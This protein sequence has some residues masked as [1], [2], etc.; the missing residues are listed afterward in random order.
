MASRIIN[1]FDHLCEF[2][3]ALLVCGKAWVHLFVPNRSTFLYQTMGIRWMY[4]LDLKCAYEVNIYHE[5]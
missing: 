5:F 1:Y 4:P 3:R 2:E